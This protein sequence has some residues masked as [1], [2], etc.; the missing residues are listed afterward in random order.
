VSQSNFPKQIPRRP[1]GKGIYLSGS[2][3]AGDVLKTSIALLIAKLRFRGRSFLTSG[4]RGARSR[5]GCR[6]RLEAYE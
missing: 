5:W 1:P 2:L 4:W 6:E 3:D